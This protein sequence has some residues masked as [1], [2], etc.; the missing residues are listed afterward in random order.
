MR[1][2]C[3]AAVIRIVIELVLVKHYYVMKLEHHLV[4]KFWDGYR[5]VSAIQTMDKFFVAVMEAYHA[6]I[7]YFVILMI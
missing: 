4:C 6:N 5:A 7:A 1:P 2:L 3:V